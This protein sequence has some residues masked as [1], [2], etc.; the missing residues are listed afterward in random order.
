MTMLIILAVLLLIILGEPLFMV[1]GALTVL[2]FSL[3]SPDVQ[4]ALDLMP[5]IEK[6]RD[7]AEKEVLLAIPFFVIAGAIMTK[8][9]ISAR[10]IE[11]AKALVGWLPGGL[12]V[13]TVLACG[14]FAAISGSSPATVI[15]I[16]TVMLPALNKDR[17]KEN[18]SLG[19]VTTSGSLGILIPPSIPMI[20]YCL[21]KVGG[22]KI[23]VGELFLAGVGPGIL[24][25]GMLVGYSILCGMKFGVQPQPFSWRT[26]R[27]ACKDG[28]W[29]M[30][31]PF[32]ILGGIY[33]GLFTPTEAS[34]V[35]VVYAYI[36]EAFIHRDLTL[37]DLAEVLSESARLMGALLIIMVMAMAFNDFLV[38]QNV[39][40]RTAE[41][42]RVQNLG[43]IGFLLL[44][45]LLL[46]LAGG[47]M[48]ILSAILILVPL[49]APVAESL[50]IKPLHLAIVFIVNL[51]LGYMTPPIGL[52][53]FVSAGVFQK[54]LGQV[55]RAVLPTLS[56]MLLAVVIV[57]FVPTVQMGLVNVLR[58]Q[59]F[60]EPFPSGVKQTDKIEQL[61]ELTPEPAADK[62][63]GPPGLPSLQDL[64]DQADKDFKGKDSDEDNDK[65]PKKKKKSSGG[66]KSLH[67][68]TEQADQKMRD[69]ED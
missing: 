26:L 16:G 30:S 3:I 40:D 22:E 47:V 61:Q 54:S 46:I 67:E 18:F 2:C 44:I 29:A 38:D 62:P 55:V 69:G 9:Q 31:L 49:L 43:P 24:I 13:A 52:N 53:L 11:V 34:A 35:A 14:F 66:L 5:M 21:V 20:V 10:L 8:G 42:L 12:A 36:V 60:Y 65:A 17:Y 37:S 63:S 39:P 64:T 23:D 27:Q 50:G 6:I 4:T 33:S 28:M 56:I 7:L 1:L 32:V 59:S 48:D 58:G 45:N 41:W 51:E 68:L 19:L 57:T 25:C 15:A